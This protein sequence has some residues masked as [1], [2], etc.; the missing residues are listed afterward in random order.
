M[1]SAQWM[2]S[3]TTISGSA[4]A[5]VSSRRRTAQKISVTE[6]VSSVS[7]IAASRRATTSSLPGPV[8]AASLAR[9]S[10]SGSSAEIPAASRTTSA[11]GQKVIPSP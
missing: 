5:S 4:L 3:N 11:R 6:N 10:S 2:S 9:A 1:S 8:T 7:P